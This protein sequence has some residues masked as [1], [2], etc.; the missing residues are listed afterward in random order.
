MLARAVGLVP[1]VPAV[2]ARVLDGAEREWRSLATLDDP[3]H[4]YAYC[5]CTAP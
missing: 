4:V 5:G 3:R 1:A 2:V